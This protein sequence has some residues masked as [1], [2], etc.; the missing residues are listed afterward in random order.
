M[1]R[2]IIVDFLEDRAAWRQV[3][4]VAYPQDYRN[5]RCADGLYKLAAFVRRLPDDDERIR[6]L[7]M[8]CA[9]DR[10]GGPLDIFMPGQMVEDAVQ[11]FRFDR[12]DE[13]CEQ[14][15]TE[16]ISLGVEDKLDFG[17]EHNLIRW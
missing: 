17:V 4:S 3:E 9:T 11:R 14:F 8:L 16:M 1:D 2:K 5:Q 10:G 13:N 7:L 12:P 6:D 15:I